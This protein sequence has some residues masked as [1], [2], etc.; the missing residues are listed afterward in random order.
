MSKFDILLAGVGGQGTVLASKL[1]ARC[2]IARGETAHT[3]ETIGM[4]QRGGCVTSHVRVGES[5]SPL[6]PKG[7]ADAIIA[8]EPAEA[9]RALPYLKAGGAVIVNVA[10]IKPV[11]DTLSASGYTA[12]A[13]IEYLKKIPARVV[14]VD[15]EAIARECGSMKVVNMALLGAV[16]ATDTIGAT[17]EEIEAAAATLA[18]K[19]RAANA[20]SGETG[21]RRFQ[22]HTSWQMSHPKMWRPMVARSCSGTLPRNSI[23][24]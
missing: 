6:I 12:E 7:Q 2:A 24:K 1:L 4:A 13:M 5:H 18:P 19:F 16:A 11:T 23:V 20:G 3:A 22:G 17:V 10:A 15:G 9:V 8:F 21:A 14:F